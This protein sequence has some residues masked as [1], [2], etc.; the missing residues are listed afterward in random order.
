MDFGKLEELTAVDFS[1]PEWKFFGEKNTQKSELNIHLGLTG[2]GEKSWVGKIY[3]KGIKNENML[4]YYSQYYKTIEFNTTF[5]RIPEI[6]TVQKWYEKS[7]DGFLF[8]PKIPQVISHSNDFGKSRDFWMIFEESILGFKE[9]LGISF[10]QMPSHFSIQKS[11]LLFN[12]LTQNLFTIPFAIELRHESWFGA[13]GIKYLNELVEICT[14]KGIGLVHTDVAGRR[15]VMHGF[16][17]NKTVFIRFVGNKGH[18]SDYQRLKYW[19]EAFLLFGENEV[20]NV[21]FMIHQPNPDYLIQYSKTVFQEFGKEILPF[22]D[23]K[24]QQMLMF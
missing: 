17:S 7:S 24:N 3:P 19:K 15:D 13:D 5:Y 16:I 8:C 9:K 18:S 14:Q 10:L 22:L 21:F 4:H 6:S 11:K 2:W 12:F 20:E 1:L 23:E